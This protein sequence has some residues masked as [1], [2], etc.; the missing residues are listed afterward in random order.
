V[1]PAPSDAGVAERIG[2]DQIRSAIEAIRRLAD[3][4]VLHIPR[5][6][7][8]VTRVGLNLADKVLVVLQLDVLSFRAAKRAVATVGI[9]DRC[10]FVVNRFVRAEIAPSD[11]E[12]VFGRPAAAVIRAD[13][14]APAAQDRGRLLANR[15]RTG[16]AVAR[17]A[18]RILQE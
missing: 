16:R 15:G 4:V 2:A 12:R 14:A 11:V 3:I 1:L 13:R 8:D 18:D 5:G 10:L 17:L 9:E 7:D 6:L